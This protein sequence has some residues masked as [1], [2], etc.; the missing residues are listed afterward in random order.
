METIP[1]ESGQINDLQLLGLG[2]I[3]KADVQNERQPAYLQ[4][5]FHAWNLAPHGTRFG[6][7]NLD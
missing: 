4:K 6:L 1:Y 7:R 2:L 5:I 3:D